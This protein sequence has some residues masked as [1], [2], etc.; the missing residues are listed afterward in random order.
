VLLALARR[1]RSI[2]RVGS[3]RVSIE[4]ASGIDAP[5]RTRLRQRVGARGS[6][7]NCRRVRRPGGALRKALCAAR[8]SATCGPRTPSGLGPSIAT[9]IARIGDTLESIVAR[10]IF[11]RAGRAHTDYIIACG[12]Q[13]SGLGR[14]SRTPSRFPREQWS[15]CPIRAHLAHPHRARRPCPPQRPKRLPQETEPP[16]QEPNRPPPRSL[17]HPRHA[18]SAHRRPKSIP[19]APAPS[20]RSAPVAAP[21]RRQRPYGRFRRSG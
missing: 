4:R 1:C 11:R 5:A 18:R 2:A 12:S 17:P 21:L 14:T 10:A 19:V 15:H 9:L 20:Q 7:G 13:E 3:A 8:R 16:P 6:R